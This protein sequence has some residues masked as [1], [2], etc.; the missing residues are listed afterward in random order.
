MRGVAG[1][2]YYMQESMGK[3][4]SYSLSRPV[5]VHHHLVHSYSVFQDCSVRYIYD[6]F[7][8]LVQVQARATNSVSKNQ[9]P[10]RRR[11]ASLLPSNI[12]RTD[13][14]VKLGIYPPIPHPVNLELE[15]QPRTVDDHLEGKIQII[16]LNTACG[17]QSGEQMPGHRAEVRG[18]RADV[19]QIPSKSL[20]RLISLAGDEVVGDDQRLPR[21]EV[22]GVVEGDGLHGR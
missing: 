9:Q 20:G 19:H 13:Q 7:P 17:C 1:A 5:Q 8:L 11:L 3:L 12:K 14:L 2:G 4:V 21:A 15:P 18:Q 10:D 22:A 6:L 16:E